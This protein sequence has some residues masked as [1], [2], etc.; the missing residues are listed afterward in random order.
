[1]IDKNRRLI[2]LAILSTPII[3]SLPG[4]LLNIITTSNTIVNKGGW[5]LL[6][7]DS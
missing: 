5:L 3:L 1:M 7:S 6:D 4:S 2:S